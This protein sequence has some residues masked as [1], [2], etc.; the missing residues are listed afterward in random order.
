LAE[1]GKMEDALSAYQEAVELSP[2][3]YTKLTALARFCVQYDYLVKEIGLPAAQKAIE[4]A[5]DE[6]ES[7]DIYGQTLLVTGDNKQ[8]T[9]AFSVALSLNPDYAP[10][11]LHIGQAAL[12]QGDSILAKEA[13]MKTVTI[14]GNSSESETA[15][16][17]LKQYFLV[18]MDLLKK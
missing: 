3:D 1:T 10:T 2:L 13:L 4:L 12:S 14:S 5:A 15:R 17:L 18:D 6:P 7:Q 8:A 11:W 16:R 9:E